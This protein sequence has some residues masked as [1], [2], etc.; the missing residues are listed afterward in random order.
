[1][2]R[3][4]KRCGSAAGFARSALLA[5][6]VVLPGI[7]CL[8][9]LTPASA[10][11]LGTTQIKL[12]LSPPIIAAD[13]TATS[14]A[15][16]TV[17]GVPPFMDIVQFTSSDP[18]DSIVINPHDSLSNTYTATI[19]STDPGRS[20]ITA[21][22]TTA[23]FSA[24]AVLTKYGR[25]AGVAVTLNPSTIPANG[26]SKSTAIAT[27][28]DA[29]GDPV[30]GDTVTF[31]STDQG[32]KI[33]AT[34]MTGIGV[35]TATITSS[36]TPGQATITAVDQSAGVANSAML[37]Q[38]LG[39]STALNASPNPVTNQ[40]VTLFAT[41]SSTPAAA[42]GTV[43]FRD[44][45]T[46]IPGCTDVPISSTSPTAACQTSFAAA[47]SPH[48]VTA[49]FSSSTS[50]AAGSAAQ[51]VISVAKDSTTTSLT[52]SVS[53]QAG[54]R[55]VTHTAAVNPSHAGP[56]A[57]G[58]SVQF[59]SGGSVIS[60]CANQPVTQNNGVAVA[61]CTLGSRARTG[62][63]I[64]AQYLGD[65]NFLSSSS[66]P[67]H[68]VRTITSTMTWSF[69]FTPH[70]TMVR[71]LRVQGAPSGA[72]VLIRC[73]GK[74]CPFHRRTTNV[75]HGCAAKSKQKCGRTILLESRFGKHHLAV[76][77]RI[78][79]EVVRP[80]WIGKYYS[81]TMR[82]GLGPRVKIACLAP[83]QNRPAVGC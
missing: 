10:T 83:G 78:V 47:T 43:T 11:A 67:S 79:V 28:T 3:F 73:S 19:K 1:M 52:G 15:T 21:T 34:S 38:S 14:T 80:N 81:F 5:L 58:G 55:G 31:T 40:Q 26:T 27:V 64:T 77:S 2:I 6:F 32:E 42:S 71:Q 66:Q 20:T 30:P 51:Q 37:T 48:T 25:A 75:T 23:S 36:T 76:G 49:T 50:G 54:K 46:S 69:S 41:V 61:T 45:G 4:L 63:S 13:G 82:S 33:G 7:S 24:T 72:K 29:L 62:Q 60:S 68:S 39:S 44:G 22:D 35:Y 65:A 17:D 18:G 12:Q 53:G 9:L 70:Y 8:A 16:A 57:P 56:V 74:G 59:R